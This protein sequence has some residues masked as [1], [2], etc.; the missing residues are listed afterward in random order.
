VQNPCNLCGD[1][2]A[3]VVGRRGRYGIP[4]CNVMCLRCTLVWVDPR[5]A[6]DELAAWYRDRYHDEY[7]GVG[8][9]ARDGRVIPAG[10]AE[11]A[12]LARDGLE[13]RVDALLEWTDLQ[14]LP[15]ARVLEV[16]CRDGA[17]LAR[18]KE[19]CGAEVWGVEPSQKESAVARERGV[20]CFCGTLEQ[21]T[22]PA[23]PFDVVM[24]FHVLEH[25][26]DPL[27]A[28]RRIR[29]LL[30]PKGALVL[31]VPNLHRPYGS[32]E[33]NFFQSAHLFT[34]SPD[35]LH[36]L[37]LRAGFSSL[38]SAREVLFAVARPAPPAQPDFAQGAGAEW[39]L[40]HLAAYR[41]WHRVTELCKRRGWDGSVEAACKALDG[42]P[43][44]EIYK[45]HAFLRVGCAAVSRGAHV[46]AR[47][48]LER[49]AAL[50]D[51]TP[52]IQTLLRDL[53]RLANQ[54][55]RLRA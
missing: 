7:A 30:A 35:T 13:K 50:G 36:W 1:R 37:L 51:D 19:R 10:S 46:P 47:H 6:P 2:V 38:L 44:G 43:G 9:L 32:L 39:V 23:G 5:P 4:L 45:R 16:G 24:L 21:L 18:L 22:P 15:S 25:V 29:A 55:T 48:W 3:V 8:M 42:S 26:P 41:R 14:R 49:V 27:A 33:D 54:P 28:L 20:A 11:H 31:E 40:R 53:R 52:E 17:L 12:E 34:F